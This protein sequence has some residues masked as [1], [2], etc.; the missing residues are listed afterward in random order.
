MDAAD[1]FSLL[2][3]KASSI[4][5]VCNV[6][7]AGLMSQT[8][9]NKCPSFSAWL[10]NISSAFYY[11]IASKEA[12]VFCFFKRKNISEVALDVGFNQL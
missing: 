12:K 11:G 7:Q 4:N 10:T 5:R 1:A 2:Y 8:S 6:S 9:E 3:F